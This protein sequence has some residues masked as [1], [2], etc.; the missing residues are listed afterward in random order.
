M[1]VYIAGPMTG[2]PEFNFPAFNHAEAALRRAGYD[3]LS[4]ARRPPDGST[5][6][7][8]LRRALYDVLASDAVALLDGWEASRGAILEVNVAASLGMLCRP[9]THWLEGATV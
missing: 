1:I 4:P 6:A 9:V 5:W 2:L 3:V 8:Y 7:T